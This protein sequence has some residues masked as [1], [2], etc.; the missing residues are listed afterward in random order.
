MNTFFI[1]DEARVMMQETMKKIRDNRDW[2]YAWIQNEIEEAISMINAYDK[3]Y[4]LGYLGARL[5]Q[6]SASF[7]NQFLANY[8]GPDKGEIDENE[9]QQEDDHIETI[10]EYALSIATASANGNATIPTTEQLNAIYEKLG[11]IKSNMIFFEMSADVPKDGNESDQWLRFSI[12]TDSMNVRGNGF[13][14][15]VTELYNELFDPF[16]GFLETGY[17]FTH[18]DLLQTLLK[19]DGLV[20]S[21]IGNTDGAAQGHKRLQEFMDEMGKDKV[22]EN[23]HKTGKHFIQQFTEANPD[24]YNEADPVSVLMHKINSIESYPTI[25]WVIPK[26]DKEKKIFEAL[27][28]QFGDN[29]VFM[30]PPKF[31]AFPLNDTLIKEKPLVKYADKYF[32]FS[33]TLGFRNLFT[34][35]ESLICSQS[36]VFFDSMYRN[37]DNPYAR[38][39]YI[40]AK[41]RKLFEQMLPKA[42]CFRS[43]KYDTTEDRLVKHNELDLIV[44]ADETAYIVEVKAG[45]LN[46]KHRRGYLKGLKSKLDETINKGSFQCHR[47][48]QYIEANEEP[49]FTYSESG[50]RKSLKV[51]KQK[52]KNYF[53]IAVTFEQFSIVSA[54]LQRLIDA[55]IMDEEYKW[56][57]IVSVYDLMVF[58][59]LIT[60]EKDF[61]EYLTYRLGIYDTP[62]VTFEDETDVLG[63][64]FEGNFPITE[65]KENQHI[66]I[67]GFKDEIDEYYTKKGLGYPV[68]KKPAKKWNK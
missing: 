28:Q 54:H 39:N 22:F 44:I 25:F 10:L 26:T 23:W 20:G 21:K 43:V 50:T 8:D 33:S 30:K 16:A 32:H 27:S 17:G 59:E 3:V 51:D 2:Y 5:I 67:T 38:D 7:G 18:R 58:A 60:S 68:L 49:E 66:T 45:E 4:V 29:G 12:M 19:L 63:Y 36:E 61:N 31:K 24:L 55:G 9:L 65:I 56:S 37:N 35:V 64:Y 1:P 53:K 15:H 48:L 46:I 57:W 42:S 62:N 47:A 52:I 34:I 11:V 14:I 40:E 6:A 13:E 41:T